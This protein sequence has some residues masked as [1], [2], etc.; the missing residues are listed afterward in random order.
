M[1]L[2]IPNMGDYFP[3]FHDCFD[4]L[5]LPRVGLVSNNHVLRPHDISLHILRSKHS[6]ASHWKRGRQ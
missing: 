2:Y 4:Y 3:I 5:W 1:Y 6:F